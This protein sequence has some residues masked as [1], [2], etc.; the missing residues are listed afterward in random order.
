MMHSSWIQFHDLPQAL[1]GFSKLY[2]HYLDDFPKIQSFF[3]FDFRSHQ[4]I[5]QRIAQL[6]SSYLHRAE[7]ATVLAEQN[8]QFGASE[9]TFEHLKEFS[10]PKTFAVVTGQ[11]VGMLGGPLYTIY[12][13][14]TA[15]K[16]ARQ[17]NMTTPG[18]KFVPVFWLEGEDHDFEEVR[19]VGLLNPEGIPVKVEYLIGGKPLERNAGAVGDIALD[20]YLTTFFGEL[21]KCLPATEFRG[22][23]IDLLS[24]SYAP[25]TTFNRAFARLLNRYF[26]DE[27]LIFIS[28]NDSRLK[29]IVSPIFQKEITELPKV[30]QLIIQRSAELEEQYHA[31][32]KTKALNLFMFHKGGRYMIE[33]REND[34]SLKG[35]RHYLSKEELLRIAAET[36]ELLSPNVALRPVCQDLLLPTVVYVAGPSEIA[37]FAQ[38]KPVYR[39]F[40]MHMPVIY[41]R[42]SATIVEGRVEKVMEKFEIGLTEFFNNPETMKRSVVERISEV[43]IDEMFQETIRRTGDL[44]NELKFGLNY[45]DS[46]LMG[47]LEATHEKIE[48]HLRL[49]KERAGQAQDRK[50]E[51][52]LRQVAKAAN[53][54]F[55]NR[56]FQERELNLIYFLNKYGM[57]FVRDISEALEIDKFAHQILHLN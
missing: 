43:K 26:S 19:H 50:H 51:V 47:P 30:S 18:Y 17:L 8:Q 53:V 15:I 39:H 1:G 33:P 52:A 23:L 11:Q 48:S 41:P 12:K 56:S 6:E 55:P 3:D 20:T 10:N 34:F 25:Q 27:G 37:Y 7:V 4:S 31:Q 49:L 22:A 35:T 32:I 13:T 40:G 28:P 46:T 42:A 16:L 24:G 29:K 36:P 21:Q 54:L 9:K 44:L 14:I 45:I 57:D 38:L 5:P 2:Q